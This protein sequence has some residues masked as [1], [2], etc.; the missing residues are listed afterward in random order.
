MRIKNIAKT[1]NQL[2]EFHSN[3]I[4]NQRPL[5]YCNKILQQMMKCLAIQHENV[6]GDVASIITTNV[7]KKLC[8]GRGTA[9]RTCQYRKA[10]NWWTTL[11]YTQGHHSCAIKWPYGI[12]LLVCGLLFQRLYL[13][14]CSDT[15]T[16]EVNVTACDL[17]NSIHFWQRSLSYKPR[18]L[19]NLCV[20]IS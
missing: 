15:T 4:D 12:S 8:Y 5:Q 18:A 7:Y 10:C 14:P 13:G 11:T 19:S 1:E 2:G 6:K 9:R 17:E 16:F 3:C 20:N